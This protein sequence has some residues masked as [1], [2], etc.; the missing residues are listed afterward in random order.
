MR[1]LTRYI[2]RR[3]AGPFIF[4]VIGTTV[5]LLLDQVSKR[6]ERLI[7]KDLESAVIAEV[8]V[9]SIPF[10]LAQTL[11]MA[12]LVAVLY[13]FSRMEGDF[14]ITA[15]KASGIP[16]SRV[17]A[18]L[19]VCAVILAG[20]MT[21][22]NNTVLPQSNHHLQVLLTGIGRKKPTFNLREHTINEV[23]PSYVYVHPGMIDREESVVHDVAIYD[24]R[25][26]QESRS[27]YAT[28]GKM[29]FS[30]QGE[31][32]YFDLEDGVV[33]VRMNERP[34][35]FRRIAFERML[36]KIPDVANGLE[37]DTAAIRGDR[38]MNIAD[39]R[40]EA[41]RGAQ[42]ADAA[43]SESLVYAQAITAMLLDFEQPLADAPGPVVR[44]A[45]GTRT[46][47]SEIP[48]L[49]DYM[50]GR[51]DDIA[52]RKD[53]IP[54]LESDVPDWEADLPD[55]GDDLSATPGALARGEMGPEPAQERAAPDST[56][57]VAESAARRFYS[58]SDAANQF[59]SYAE[60][61]VTGLRRINQYWVEIH[62]KG[63]I[64]AACIVFVLLGAPIA[65]RFPR[66]GVALVVGVSLG[67]FG[68]YYVSLI[69][70][71]RLADRLWISP[72]WA[73]WAPNVIFGAAGLV[74]LARSTKVMR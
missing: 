8:F 41:D 52:D 28:R 36:L 13:V 35:A 17:M 1:T 19:L 30:E 59:Q 63:T 64:P 73:M 7:G 31:D 32:L 21:W 43:R 3:H 27:I 10:I 53:G 54:D 68:A 42:M 5:L 23:L 33:Q 44:P 48:D 2:L 14:E 4:A 25:N 50:A 45:G 49:D 61:E 29:G 6:F 72:L 69:G 40:V 46:G 15:V 34:H 22:F 51:L 62:K 39:M 65:V 24:E 60:R 11:P 26:G 12:V 18:P 55:R 16:L 71:E 58:A 38:E 67:I 37:R 9:Y 66:G 57:Q 20:G 74:A 70:G 47:V 56:T